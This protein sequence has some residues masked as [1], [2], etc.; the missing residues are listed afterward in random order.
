M[1]KIF[2][3]MPSTGDDSSNYRPKRVAV[4]V[5]ILSFIA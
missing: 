3:M 5:N 1:N 4:N 2:K